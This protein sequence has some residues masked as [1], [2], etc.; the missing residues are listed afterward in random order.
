MEKYKYQG[1]KQEELLIKALE[2]QNLDEKDIL[3]KITEEKVGL[4]KSK[5]YTLEFVKL[6]EVMEY[7]KGILN[8]L[9]NGF[10]TTFNVESKLRDGLIKFEIHSDNN[11]LLIGKNGRILN[12]VQT[13]LRQMIYNKLDLFPNIVI[14][15]ENYKE[16][17]NFF[18]IKNAKKLAREVTLTKSDIKLDPMNSYDRRTIHEALQNFKYVKTESEGTEPNRYVVI[19]YTEENK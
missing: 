19:K 4:L 16:K 18:L 1:K 2:E 14:D 9:L 3:Y 5:R 8:N 13:L 11:S 6:S 12:A 15:V 10:N 7:G 17:Q